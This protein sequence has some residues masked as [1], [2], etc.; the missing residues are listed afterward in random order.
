M[1]RNTKVSGEMAVRDII[2][3]AI[4][5]NKIGVKPGKWR[6]VAAIHDSGYGGRGGWWVPSGGVEDAGIRNDVSIV[7]REV[8]EV[9]NDELV[10][11]GSGSVI[12]SL[13]IVIVRGHLWAKVGLENVVCSLHSYNFFLSFCYFLYRVAK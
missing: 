5:R 11:R 9:L 6:G 1:Y 8:K 13:G 2:L 12:I 7:E 3:P 10:C 4:I